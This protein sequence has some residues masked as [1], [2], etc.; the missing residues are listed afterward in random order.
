LVIGD[1]V[2]WG[3]GARLLGSKHSGV[4]IDVPIIATDLLIAQ[5]VIEADADIGV[6]AVIMPGV[7]I[8][9]GAIVGAGAVV[10]KDVPAYSKVAGSPA[11]VIGYRDDRHFAA[12]AAP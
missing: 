11:Q 1:N 9:R 6:N 7:T 3:P 10:T 5:V 8:G 2:G 4:P 12:G